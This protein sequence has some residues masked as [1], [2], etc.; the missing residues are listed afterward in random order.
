MK[1]DI[2]G[3][4]KTEKKKI[5]KTGSIPTRGRTFKGKIIKKFESRV[6]V[7]FERTIKVGKYERFIKKKTKLH[8]RII[9]G[10][11]IKIGDFVKVRECRPLSKIVHFIVIEVLE[12]K[13][14]SN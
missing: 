9:K 12:D 6:V 2:K 5:V 1:K 11:K 14:E 10:T 8:A 4:M 13:N 3:K 7:E